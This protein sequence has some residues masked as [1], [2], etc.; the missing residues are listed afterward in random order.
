[1]IDSW[2]I[3]NTKFD[4]IRTGVEYEFD[5][6]VLLLLHDTSLPSLSGRELHFNVTVFL[7]YDQKVDSE[8]VALNLEWNDKQIAALQVRV[9]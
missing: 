4:T 2:S 8:D 7:S 3:P 5:L 9:Q 1:M 6:V